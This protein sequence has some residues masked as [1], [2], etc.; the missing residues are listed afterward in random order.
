M[1]IFRNANYFQIHSSQKTVFQIIFRNY[2]FRKLCLPKHTRHY[3]LTLDLLTKYFRK[4]PNSHQLTQIGATLSCDVIEKDD[5]SDG[6]NYRATF[7]CIGQ[8]PEQ[9]VVESVSRYF[10]LIELLFNLCFFDTDFTM[11]TL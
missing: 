1:P 2:F 6:V 5:K 3:S 8:R 4:S 9:A 11:Y 10:I 7:A